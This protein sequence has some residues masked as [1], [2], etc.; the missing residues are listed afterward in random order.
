MTQTE[1]I[2]VAKVI[3]PTGSDAFQS[4]QVLRFAATV[5][6]ATEE[7]PLTLGNVEFWIGR[8]V[9]Q[10]VLTYSIPTYAWD[11]SAVKAALISYLDGKED[12]LRAYLHL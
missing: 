3:G 9:W 4:E 7:H 6:D 8:D 11:K 1:Q 10:G 2:K 12:A 5:A